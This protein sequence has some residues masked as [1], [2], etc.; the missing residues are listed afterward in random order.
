[1]LELAGFP[2]APTY[3]GQARIKFGDGRMRDVEFAA[4][5]AK[6]TLP[7]C[8]LGAD[9]PAFLRKGALEALGG[10]LD[11]LRDTLMLGFRGA[12][13]PLKVNTMGCSSLG[14]VNFECCRG[15]VK[16]SPNF[17]AAVV[18]KARVRKRPNL[19]NGGNRLPPPYFPCTQSGFLGQCTR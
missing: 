16:R 3:S 9:I 11:F 6:G 17:S 15:G 18:E 13:I 5:W 10:R 2:R 7:A 14:V 1:M 8:A 4:C 12:G 19:E